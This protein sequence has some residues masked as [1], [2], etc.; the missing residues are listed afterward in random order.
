MNKPIIV[1]GVTNMDGTPV[2]Y[3]KEQQEEFCKNIAGNEYD[4][5]FDETNSIPNLMKSIITYKTIE[6]YE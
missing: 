6:S 5:I 2:Q 4:V 1:C 3:T